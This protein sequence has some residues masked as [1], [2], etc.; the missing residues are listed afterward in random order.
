[1]KTV[2]ALYDD[3]TAAQNA[4]QD[5][6]NAGFPR[7]DISLVA[8]DVAGSY[9]KYVNK[10]GESIDEDAVTAGE[11]A[12]FGGVVGA[13]TGALVGLGALAIAGIGA[14]FAAG[15][16]LARLGGGAVCRAA[17]EVASGIAC[18]LA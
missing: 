3:L 10:T 14:V 9:G 15:L 16:L 2:V 11:G 17:G 5:L 18:A 4:V 6:V 1:M 7:A 13:L 12:S 8:Q